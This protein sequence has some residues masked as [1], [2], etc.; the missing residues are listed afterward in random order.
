MEHHQYAQLEGGVSLVERVE[1]HPYRHLQRLQD[2]PDIPDILWV[3][4]DDEMLLHAVSRS[5][6]GHRL[7]IL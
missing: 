5:E 6:C 3:K 4:D 2:I 7:T 1:R